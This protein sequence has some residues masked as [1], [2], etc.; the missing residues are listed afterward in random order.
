MLLGGKAVVV[1]N[2]PGFAVCKKLTTISTMMN[3]AAR[4]TQKS[5]HHNFFLDPRIYRRKAVTANAMPQSTLFRTEGGQ[6]TMLEW[7]ACSYET[8]ALRSW[9]MVGMMP[10][11]GGSMSGRRALKAARRLL[12]L[13]SFA[14]QAT[15]CSDE[16]HE[17][18][19]GR[20]N[21]S[22]VTTSSTQAAAQLLRI[23]QPERRETISAINAVRCARSHNVHGGAST[24]T[25]APV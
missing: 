15:H 9:L 2:S 19:P 10:T 4:M 22:R 13:F 16:G 24:V 18:R 23:I 7:H 6:H 17:A 3:S 25:A 14:S 12:W 1:R 8:Y 11:C 20:Y 5:S 21:Q